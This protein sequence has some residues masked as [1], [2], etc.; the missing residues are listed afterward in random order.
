QSTDDTGVT[1]AGA[2]TVPDGSGGVVDGPTGGFIN[3]GTYNGAASYKAARLSGDGGGAKTYWYLWYDSSAARHRLT[4]AKGSTAGA[5]WLGPALGDATGS[6]TA[7]NGASGSATVSMGVTFTHW[8]GWVESLQP[9]VN[10]YGERVVEITAAGPMQFYKAAETALALQENRRTDQII[11]ELVQEVVIPPAQGAG[12]LLGV[13]GFMELGITTV[14]AA[15]GEDYSDLEEGTVTLAL[16]ADNWVRRG[17]LSNESKDTFNVYR[18]IQDVVAAE[19]GRFFFDREGRAVFW[20]R[21]H[22]TMYNAVAA[23]FNNTMTDLAY[24]YAGT[25]HFKNDVRVK[26]HPRTLGD[27]DQEVLWELEDDIRVSAGST[28]TIWAKFEDGSGNRIGGKDITVT[29]VVFS[30][31]SGTVTL[32]ARANST[33]L[34][35]ENTGTGTAVLSGCKVRGRKITDFGALEAAAEDRI[36]TAQYGRRTLNLNLPSVDNFAQA[37]RI[38]KYELGRRKDPRGA[39]ES[40][41]LTSRGG[42]GGGNHTQQL[43]RTLGDLINVQEAQT[44]HDGDYL[45]VGEAHDLSDGGALYKTTW[46]LEPAPAWYPWLLGISGRCELGQNTYL[47]F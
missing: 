38:A 16:A 6:Y 37:E 25:E 2:L 27:T 18:A 9:A 8:V 23:E 40:L 42:E 35:V 13:P 14:L 33:Q 39:V 15:S 17:G 21:H 44:D 7:E 45:I 22:T 43:A 4:A 11:A 46:Y 10:Q 26:C 12:W 47:G 36:S 28:R 41:T 30:Q 5:R 1:V 31:G 32:D 20:N 3:D 34:V 24:T 19:R 29:D